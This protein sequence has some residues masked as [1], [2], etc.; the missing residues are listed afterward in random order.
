MRSFVLPPDPNDQAHWKIMTNVCRLSKRRYEDRVIIFHFLVKI[1]QKIEFVEPECFAFAFTYTNSWDERRRK[2]TLTS[3]IGVQIFSNN[4]MA[5]LSTG[6]TNNRQLRGAIITLRGSLRNYTAL[7]WSVFAS[8]ICSY[9][10]SN[11]RKHTFEKA[12]A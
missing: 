12:V 9:Q 3:R 11:N 5:K 2:I 1:K 7:V 8:P 10:Y 4:R 6:V